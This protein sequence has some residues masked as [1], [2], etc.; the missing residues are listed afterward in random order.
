MKILFLHLS[1]IHCEEN[2]NLN[3]KFNRVL[4]AVNYYSNIDEIVLICSGDITNSGHANEYKNI[5]RFLGKL[6]SDL[7]R[8]V[9]GKFI[10]SLMI[11]G[12][13]DLF[14]PKNDF[15][16]AKDVLSQLNSSE[17]A[18]Y[19]YAYQKRLT[20]FYNYAN[21]K[22][23]FINDKF[24]EQ[25]IESF[26]GI[27]I[28]F[29]LVNTAP[30]SVS[31]SD[32]K[33]SHYLPVEKIYE[34]KKASETDYCITIMH[35]GPEWF[36]YDSKRTLESVLFD[37]CEMIFQGHEHVPGMLVQD[38]EE[39]QRILISKCGQFSGKYNEESAFSIVVLDTEINKCTENI[40]RW[41]PDNDVFTH[42][43]DNVFDIEQK[44]VNT[45]S[46]KESFV[47]ALT[48]DYEKISDSVLD[49]YTFPTL[50]V[51]DT[52]ESFKVDDTD[53]FFDLLKSKKIIDI[54]G[55]KLSGKTVTLKHLYYESIQRGYFPLY[56]DETNSQSRVS[57]IIKNLFDEQYSDRDPEYNKY[58]Y[59]DK[60]KKIIFI[61][62]FD[63]FSNTL[64]SHLVEHFANNF[65]H[66]VFTTDN[67]IS[68]N[69]E[70]DAHEKLLSEI[71]RVSDVF[72]LVIRD[73]Y[74]EKRC[75]LIQNILNLDKENEGINFDTLISTVDYLV[76]KK[77]ELFELKP[78]FIIQYVKFFSTKNNTEKKKTD[79]VFNVIFETN[80]RNQ[81]IN[82]S[83]DIPVEDV[84]TFFEEL[85][86]RMHF[87]LMSERFNIEDVQEVS[88]ICAKRDVLINPKTIINTMKDAC[89][90]REMP[91][92]Y[93]YEF[94]SVNYLAYF[95]AKK[96]SKLV[97]KNSFDI[98]EIHIILNYICHSINDNIVLFLLYL[99]N[100][101]NFTVNLCKT[102][103]EYLKNIDEIDFDNPN[104]SFISNV[105]ID[106]LSIPNSDDK[107]KVSKEKSKRERIAKEQQNAEL[108][109]KK[110]YDYPENIDSVQHNIPKTIKYMEV[111]CKSFISLFN[112]FE[113][114]EK[115]IIASTILSAPNR[116][117]YYY[118][119]KYDDEYDALLADLIQFVEENDASDEISEETIK[120]IIVS[121]GNNICLGLYDSF[122][123]ALSSMK[124]SGFF[125]RQ[126]L[127]SS[128]N[129][130]FNLMITE[131][132]GDTEMFFNDTIDFFD[133]AKNPHV[134]YLIKRIVQKHIL[135]KKHIE[136][137]L[138]D[139]INKKLFNGKA[140]PQLLLMNHAKGNKEK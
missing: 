38:N 81:I 138:I 52:S 76:S 128:A 94:A 20:N 40:F 63:K 111:I 18:K 5:K 118:L 77:Y 75:Q 136:Y 61:D 105:N 119:K 137:Q 71:N 2:E 16:K 22:K 92:D 121:S 33:E 125:K 124:I 11:P 19:F 6:V 55:K 26:N 31:R 139:K 51:K 64:R 35:H 95:V 57:T 12:N 49:Y 91:N 28:Q 27:K 131:N 84:L 107:K 37:N 67:S 116:I 117:L 29:N 45:L 102:V 59:L 120:N 68:L 85:A 109:M 48:F 24:V 87:T 4:E 96:V 3:T 15:P 86:Y 30:F 46:P 113:P 97:E 34:L 108:S 88:E 79:A 9:N 41:D 135:V 54:R 83:K 69:L 80:I 106:E 133:N 47:K 98:P 8:K 114:E 44:R 126:D 115:S 130:I 104:I 13:H 90:I 53:S 122:A 140:K 50:E 70:T 43:A 25:R 10:H 21:M 74:K 23:C 56:L 112:D 39:N 42:S 1:D 110:L 100:N 73:F 123:F 101:T 14:Y 78:Y 17:T 62:D 132:V 65:E 103:Q 60:D 127:S 36:C 7:G 82:N 89:I 129:K 58:E 32:N 66:I 99:R 134:K 72:P 93:S